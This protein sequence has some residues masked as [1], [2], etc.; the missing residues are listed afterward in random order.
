MPLRP[1]FLFRY[2]Q[3]L[4]LLKRRARALEVFRAVARHDPRHAEAWSCAAFLL[5]QREDYAPAIDAFERACAPQPDE[6]AAHFNVA[7][8]L[9]RIGRHA[10]AIPRFQRALEPDPQVDRAWYGLGLRTP[11]PA[12]SS[13]GSG[14]AS[15]SATGCSPN[16]SASRASI[17]AS[18]KGSAT[19]LESLSGIR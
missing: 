10:E 12:I 8:L 7:F 2:G 13:P 14:T 3:L 15:A 5:A 16:T 9:Q 6:A 4:M 11:M 19:N 17:P 1:S 18:P